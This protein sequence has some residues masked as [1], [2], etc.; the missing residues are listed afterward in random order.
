MLLVDKPYVY[1]SNLPSDFAGSVPNITSVI[2]QQWIEVPVKCTLM[3]S[4]FQNSLATYE[5]ISTSGGTD[6]IAFAK[7]LNVFSQINT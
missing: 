5:D 7:V 1:D 2:N 4:N 6:F 3:I